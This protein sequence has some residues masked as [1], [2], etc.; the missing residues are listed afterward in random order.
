MSG[1]PTLSG[2]TSTLRWSISST[3]SEVVSAGGYFFLG[4]GMWLEQQVAASSIRRVH[5]RLEPVGAEKPSRATAFS[6]ESG[7][8]DSLYLRPDR[9]TS[10]MRMRL[11]SFRRP[12]SLPRYLA[13][14]CQEETRA[15]RVS[16]KRSNQ[17]SISST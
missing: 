9:L 1:F 14:T 8:S 17:A 15:V 10:V 11:G 4:L 16:G 7:P 2:V 6:S 3:R 5:E 12:V 13:G